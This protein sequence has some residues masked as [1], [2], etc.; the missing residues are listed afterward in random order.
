MFVQKTVQS[1][2]FYFDLSGSCIDVVR[3]AQFES[4]VALLDCGTI[5]VFNAIAVEAARK[6]SKA[7]IEIGDAWH[8][9]LQSNGFASGVLDVDYFCNFHEIS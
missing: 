7:V 4:A 1:I 6:M 8:E 9:M 2:V 3:L 5:G